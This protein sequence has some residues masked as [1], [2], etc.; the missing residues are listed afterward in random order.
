MWKYREDQ[1][2]KTQPECQPK[3]KKDYAL[4]FLAEQNLELIEEMETLK[5]NIKS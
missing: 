5:K 1:H 4:S 2:A 3:T